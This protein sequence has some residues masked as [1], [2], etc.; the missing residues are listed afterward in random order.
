[1]TRMDAPSGQETVRPAFEPAD[2]AK[3]VSRCQR[4]FRFVLCSATLLMMGLSWPLWVETGAFPRVPF[5]LGLPEFTGPASWLAFGLLLLAVSAAAVGIAWRG[6]LVA[7]MVMLFVLILQDQHRFQPW[8][9]Q[10]AMTAL[11]LATLGR[12][13]SLG[14]ARLFLI[15]LYCHSGLS[16]LDASFARGLGSTFLETAARLVRVDT[17]H[18]PQESRLAAIVVM[19]ACEIAIAVGLC[20]HTTRR[21]ALA[22]VVV[23][24]LAL[25]AIL[26]PWGLRQSAIVLIWNAA[27]V[28]EDLLLF[29][30][31]ALPA[32]PVPEADSRWAVMTRWAFGLGVLM[33][34]GERCGI[35]DS[36][37]SFALYA[38]HV[39]RTDVLVH[40]S[41]LDILPSAI[42]RH[43]L[44]AGPSPWRKLDL[45]GWSRDVR[46]VPVYPQ[47]RACLGVAEALAKRY[48]LAHLLQVTQ[49]SRADRWSGH[50]RRVECWGFSAI[51]RQG[52]RYH[53]NAHPAPWP[54]R[55]AQD[56]RKLGFN[57]SKDSPTELFWTVKIGSAENQA[58]TEGKTRCGFQER[59][60]SCFIPHRC[61][62]V[63]VSATWARRPMRSSNSSRRQASGGGRSCRSG[64]RATATHRIN[65][66]RR[67]RAIR[68]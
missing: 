10:Y 62:A 9:Y 45:T 35:W 24:H 11:A 2:L 8:V 14:F 23:L 21:M 50:R 20:F 42:R 26:G 38:S 53:L 37:P 12:V 59:A 32:D 52:D 17:E 44:V 34:L 7:S 25:L 65:L 29:G 36:W 30:S 18:W 68:S 64:Q 39:E 49:W 66:T 58:R 40:E 28:L 67:S 19:P 54:L 22:G 5:V 63:S 27:L 6:M 56:A 16:K 3:A 47:A 4:R 48:P 60:E 31:I 1:M 43:A 33:P 15:A 61:Q 13:R 51:A 55:R 57:R 46:G 41:D